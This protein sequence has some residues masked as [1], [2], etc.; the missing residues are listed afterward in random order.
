VTLSSSRNAR[1][2]KTHVL[3]LSIT[4]RMDRLASRLNLAFVAAS[5]Q[6]PAVVPIISLV[7]IFTLMSAA[8]H[9]GSGLP[10]RDALGGVVRETWKRE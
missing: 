6:E 8:P 3:A 7:L 10:R 4:L 1:P 2:R 5:G 9:Q